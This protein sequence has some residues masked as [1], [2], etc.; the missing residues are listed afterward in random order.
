MARR[1]TPLQDRLELPHIESIE[2]SFSDQ[3]LGRFTDV[4]RSK[5]LKACSAGDLSNA[6]IITEQ[7]VG[8][9][10]VFSNAHP[11]EERFSERLL[12]SSPVLSRDCGREASMSN[13]RWDSFD[14]EKLVSLSSCVVKSEIGILVCQLNATCLNRLSLRHRHLLN[15]RPQSVARLP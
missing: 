12:E 2:C 8:K 13:L 4:D 15:L 10:E 3:L 6:S 7:K 9:P 5:F 14:A 1:E 11:F